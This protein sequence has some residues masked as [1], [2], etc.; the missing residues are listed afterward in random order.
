MKIGI[1]RARE[2]K[3]GPRDTENNPY[4]ETRYV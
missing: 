1:R 4:D 2:G 3:S